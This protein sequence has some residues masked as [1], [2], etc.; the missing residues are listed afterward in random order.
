MAPLMQIFFKHQTEYPNI[1][2]EFTQLDKR[3]YPILGLM[4][5]IA[6]DQ[7]K[8]LLVVTRILQTTDDKT[9][10][11]NQK[12]PYRFIDIAILESGLVTSE[13]LRGIINTRYPYGIVG[14]DTIPPL[15]HGTSPHFH[16][17][18]RPL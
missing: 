15:E 9:T 17:Q 16:V 11:Y 2:R 7:F 3:L 4:Q 5:S 18:V 10:H 12:K 8:D 14:F 13:R 6:W 1:E